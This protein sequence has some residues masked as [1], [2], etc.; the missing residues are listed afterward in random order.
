[1]CTTFFQ[2]P[3][4]VSNIWKKGAGGSHGIQIETFLHLVLSFLL[5]VIF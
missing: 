4:S 5:C 1:M 3:T 2:V